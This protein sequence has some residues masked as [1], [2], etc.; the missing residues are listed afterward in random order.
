MNTFLDIL[1]AICILI[2][3]FLALTAAIGIVR[4]PDGGASDPWKLPYEEAFYVISGTLTLTVVGGESVVVP[5]GE[6][7]TLEKGC[8]VVYEGEPGTTA[9]FCLVPANWLESVES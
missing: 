1:A 4:F 5:A 2:G 7:V 3:S 6:V 9:F 8:T